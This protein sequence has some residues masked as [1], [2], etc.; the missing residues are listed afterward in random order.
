M[1]T[2]ITVE[3]VIGKRV[4]YVCKAIVSVNR[5]FLLMI[6]DGLGIAKT[7]TVN[8]GR[9]VLSLIVGILASIRQNS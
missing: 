5:G 8:A 9:P 1:Y 4:I 7:V 6:I 3:L 2:I